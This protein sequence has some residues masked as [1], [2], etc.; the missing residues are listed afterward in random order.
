[1]TIYSLF[2]LA[3]N[4]HLLTFNLPVILFP[5]RSLDERL[6]QVDRRQVVV[7]G[8]GQ[9]AVL[10]LAAIGRALDLEQVGRHDNF[11]ALGGHSLLT[12]KV[13]AEIARQT[14][15][16]YYVGVDAA[17]G[18][19]GAPPLSS[20]IEPNNVSTTLAGT[21]DTDFQ[22]LLMGWLLAAICGALTFEWL[23]RRLSKLA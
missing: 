6:Q 22:R 4:F 10:G 7:P 14:G 20:V 17:M 5:I 1:M 3:L 11:F 13:A 2:G 23:I 21:P 18:R 19:L 15:G 12:M 8:P 9:E 16:E